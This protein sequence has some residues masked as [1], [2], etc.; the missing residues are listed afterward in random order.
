MHLP[1]IRPARH[2]AGF[3][4]V[5]VLVAIVIAA[6]AGSSLLLG[7]CS[8]LQNTND[9]MRQTMTL[10][11]AQQLLDEIVGDRYLDYG[12]N[13]YPTTLGPSPAKVSGVSR[14]LFTEIG[15]FNGYQSSPPV[16]PWGIPLGTE[17]GQGG[18]RHPNFVISP[19]LLSGW[20]QQVSVYYVGGTNFTTPL[21]AGQTSDYLAVDV[22][23]LFLDPQRGPLVWAEVRRVISYVAPLQ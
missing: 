9:G 17:D 10:G 8:S 21:P 18:T 2:A 23:I 19:N 6:F 22:K 15:D 20:Q 12:A 5:E 13:P 11:M 14:Q 7:I 4:F 16:D 1:L 3:T